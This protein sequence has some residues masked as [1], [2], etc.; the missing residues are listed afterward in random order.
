M[1][2]W[3]PA[4]TYNIREDI[5]RRNKRNYDHKQNKLTRECLRLEPSYYTLTLRERMAIRQRVL[6]GN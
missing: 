4:E 6:C 5:T 3:Y 2:N 1:T